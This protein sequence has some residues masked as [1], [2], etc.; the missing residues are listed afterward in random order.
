[1]PQ[2]TRDAAGVGLLTLTLALAVLLVGGAPRWAA[3]AVAVA[4]AAGVATT[5]TSRRVSA[6]RSPLLLLLLA[7][8]ALTAL[9]LVPLPAAWFEVLAPAT[10]DL[11]TDSQGLT[12]GGAGW[13][14]ASVDPPATAR[15]LLTG[16]TL[17][18]VAVLALRLGASDR[19]RRQLLTMVAAV[20]AL[21]ALI[22]LVHEAV[23]ARALFGLYRPDHASPTVLGPLLNP[24]SYAALLVV[25]AIIAAGLTV[26]G[27]QALTRVGWIGAALLDV[28]VALLTLSRGAVVALVVGAV[29]LIAVLAAQRAWR[30][31]PELERRPRW[32][33][34]LPALT[35]VACALSMVVYLS[36]GAVGR[37][38][39]HTSLMA[40][41][42]EP[43]SKFEVWRASTT[44]IKEHPWLGVGRGGFETAFTRVH[45]GSAGGLASHVENE[46]LQT[47]VDFGIPG[48]LALGVLVGACLLAALRRWRDGPLAAAALAALAALATSASVDFGIEL[49][50][51]AIPAVLLMSTLCHVPL[52][53]A[54]ASSVATRTRRIALASAILVAAVV[55]VTPIGRG[56][57][58]DRARLGAPGQPELARSLA[59]LRRHPLD[60][61]S[62]GRAAD[63]AFRSGDARAMRLLNHALAL[64]PTLPG[65]HRLAARVLLAAGRP[66]QAALEYRLAAAASRAP[67][68]MVEEIVASFA[69]ATMAAAA[70]P[71]DH[72]N[73]FL[74][75]RPLG[76]LGRTDLIQRYYQ[77][78]L[79][80]HPHQIEVA[81]ALYRIAMQGRDWE[82]AEFAARTRHAHSPGLDAR[83][84]LAQVLA[85][86]GD[87]GG[88]IDLAAA[89]PALTSEPGRALRLLACEAHAGLGAVAVAE[90]CLRE[91]AAA[92]STD[93]ELAGIDRRR[94]AVVSGRLQPDAGGADA[95][96]PAGAAVAPP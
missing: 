70:L 94:R 12:G 16:L 87:H 42:S 32:G 69:D 55:V 40:E 19:G 36:G 34:S 3:A 68:R 29:V 78:V 53:D 63:A 83:L 92:A 18:G 86:R 39:S 22:G 25:G 50:G 31:Q 59:A 5:I 61:L 33:T 43:A 58:E 48:A 62:A 66:A 7:G 2:R 35:I 10:H 72:P 38:L 77:A 80:A 75:S 21:A 52:R 14:A 13:R 96:A 84:D 41:M 56:V 60:F 54:G 1:M 81:R 4:A 91:V 74:I 9:Q 79:R 26:T 64:H 20:A 17:L 90:A 88:V 23:G 15:A 6:R 95:A 44:L 8:C 51:L 30:E 89:A 37:Q 93:A 28:G 47:V 65:L 45:P 24:N 73:P 46:Y 49:I 82:L 71:V 76:D 11:I 57:D 27:Q 85:R 67:R